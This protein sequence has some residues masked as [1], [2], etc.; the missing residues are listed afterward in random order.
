MMLQEKYLEILEE[1]DWSICSYT[2]D[3]R[4]EL[5]K[6]SPAGEDFI[7]CVEV[8][9]FP[10]AVAEYYQD[11][12]V[13]EHIEMWI[14]AKNNG[15]SGVPSVRM[16]VKDAEKIEEML[17]ELADALNCEKKAATGTEDE[18]LKVDIKERALELH[19]DMWLWI[20]R[21]I[22][23]NRHTQD[24]DDLK[25]K[26]IERYC[27]GKNISYNCFAC[28]YAYRKAKEKYGNIYR[29]LHYRCEFCPLE[30]NATGD[31]E[32]RC[33]CECNNNDFDD[34]T[35]LYARCRNIGINDSNKNSWK[36]QAKLAYKIAM[37]PEKE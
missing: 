14:E 24:I 17:E 2:D 6:Y 10:K 5:E 27:S 31:E 20:S 8:E 16:L 13:D 19:R 26:Y 35:G 3:G 34:E 37:L 29:A 12:D 23:K 30:W 18:F 4:V 32:G 15:V 22:A 36:K 33:M 9:N 1:L 21:E 28:E 7:M 11:F 25:V